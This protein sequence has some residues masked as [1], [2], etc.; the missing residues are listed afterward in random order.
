MHVGPEK[1][2]NDCCYKNKG[3]LRFDFYIKNNDID[4]LIEV[5]GIQHYKPIDFFGGIDGF[6]YQKK[7]DEIKRN[8]CKKNK[9]TLLEISYLEIKDNSYKQKIFNFINT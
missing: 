1:K 3:K 6:E 2:D 5:N 8:F 4:Y 7:R 9:I